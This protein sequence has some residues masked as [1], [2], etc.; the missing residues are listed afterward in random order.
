[1]NFKILTVLCV[2]CFPVRFGILQLNLDVEKSSCLKRENVLEAVLIVGHQEDGT[3]AAIR[4]V[5]E[6]AS[7]LEAKN[8]KVHKFYDKDT[9]WDKITAVTS[10]ASILVYSGHGSVM[11]EGG[12]S[13]GLCLN[14]MVSSKE[15]L[16]TM[17]LKKNALVVFQSVCRGAGSS[18]GD[19]TDIGIAEAKK[20]V[21]NYSKPFFAI[22][23]GC[24]YANNYHQGCL[25]F[26]KEVFAGKSAQN[27][28]K[29]TA[30]FWTKIE[31]E[32]AYQYDESKLISIASS[33][34][35]GKV[36][37]TTYVNGVKKVEEVPAVKS[38]DIAYVA[39]PA[40]SLK[41]VISQ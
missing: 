26:L 8:V 41:S 25:D 20:R 19:D 21:T 4:K 30:S 35:N 29:A 13:G 27:G 7:F 15:M 9:D 39:S 37:R 16:E 32:E 14:D 18:A 17:R 36:T 22:G 1:M 33:K 10:N 28:F 23:A 3:K 5:D 31:F 24:Y 6:I 2:L 40:F 12:V 38:Y 34:A 11:G